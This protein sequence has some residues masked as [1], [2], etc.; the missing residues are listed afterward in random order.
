MYKMKALCE[1]EMAFMLT[2][3]QAKWVPPGE[4]A[5]HLRG[6]SIQV[7]GLEKLFFVQEE[8]K[9]SNSEED[10]TE[11]LHIEVECQ[12]A[13]ISVPLRRN[14]KSCRKSHGS[15]FIE[16]RGKSQFLKL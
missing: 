15:R 11:Q 4:L 9:Q 12:Q 13:N 16:N 8:I 2:E 14:R 1:N 6:G 10:T 7:E 5:L 3:T